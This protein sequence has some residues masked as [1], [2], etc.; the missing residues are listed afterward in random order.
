VT[1]EWR[2]LH[3][4]TR[5]SVALVYLTIAG[6]IVAFAAY[7]YALRHMDV[8]IV[9]LYTYIN[10]VIAVAL[11]IVALGEPFGWRML[12]AIAIIVTGVALTNRS[13]AAEDSGPRSG[14]TSP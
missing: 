5:T 2:D 1:G 10:P 3:F 7:S 6:S 12:V 11:G 4:T 14:G 9:S 13:R 8:A